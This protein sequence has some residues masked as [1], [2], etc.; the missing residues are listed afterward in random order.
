M[1][2]HY[3]FIDQLEGIVAK[4]P[5]KIAF[6]FL[7]DGEAESDY[8]SYLQIQAKA[9]AIAATLQEHDAAGERALLFYPPGI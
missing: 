5:H 6:T 3:T 1:D 9:K 4:Q 7:Q 8:F 2:K